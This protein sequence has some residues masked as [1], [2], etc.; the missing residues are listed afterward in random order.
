M[1]FVFVSKKIETPWRGG[2]L[3]IAMQPRLWWPGLHYM[4]YT[5]ECY[6]TTTLCALPSILTM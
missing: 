6:F 5:I 1:F 3:L 4:R 2:G